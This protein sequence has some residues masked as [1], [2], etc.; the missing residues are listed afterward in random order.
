MT[1]SYGFLVMF[2]LTVLITGLFAPMMLAQP[3]L[4]SEIRIAVIAPL[5]GP[6]SATAGR[7]GREGTTLAAQMINE[8]GGIRG[9]QIILDFYDDRADP[10]E[11]TI[12]AQRVADDPRYVAVIAHFSTDSCFAAL[13][14]Y[15]EVNLP[16]LTAWASHADLT[17]RFDVSFRFSASTEIFGRAHAD[18][19]IEHGEGPRVATISAITEYT[20]DHLK[21]F[22]ERLISEGGQIVREETFY[23]GDT[24]FTPQIT[25]LRGSNPDVLAII[26]Y[27]RESA[28][29]LRQARDLGLNAQVIAN[30]LLAGPE[31]EEI[32]G[33]HLDGAYIVGGV[34]SL[35]MQGVF[36]GHEDVYEYYDRYQEAYGYVPRGAWDAQA[37]DAVRVIAHAVDQVGADREDVLEFLTNLRGFQGLV[38][39]LFGEDRAMIPNIIFQRYNYEEKQYEAISDLIDSTKYLY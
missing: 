36:E 3:T 4:P 9:S 19:V 17:R 23:T 2:L 24:D 37:F 16:M 35:M 29:I 33:R 15:E 10:Q 28:L 11:S 31:V 8:K 39:V 25:N 7:E 18:L 21:H 27:P 38:G 14:I 22:K 1:K 6:L 26:G 34:F 12:I 30:P 5:S 13:P 32:T 20:L